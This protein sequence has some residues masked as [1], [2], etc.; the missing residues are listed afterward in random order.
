[1]IYIKIN[2]GFNIFYTELKGNT[3][4]FNKIYI[5][6]EQY[7]FELR[8]SHYKELSQ[9]ITFD[10]VSDEN[11]IYS[12]DLD[13]SII[14]DHN[15]AES[16]SLHEFTILSE[17]KNIILLDDSVSLK[18]LKAELEKSFDYV[19]KIKTKLNTIEYRKN[20]IRGDFD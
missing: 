3:F 19:E 17:N 8:D 16:T 6:A 4:K 10:I 5:G 12:V 11:D 13:V 1:M 18:L 15:L 9:K 7:N 14:K 2:C 20:N